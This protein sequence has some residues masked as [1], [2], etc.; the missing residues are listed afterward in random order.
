MSSGLQLPSALRG[1]LIFLAIVAFSA[2]FIA[3]EA[4][5]ADESEKAPVVTI[6][7]CFT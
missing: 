3:K 6:E 2:P 5:G 1:L 7:H 4:V